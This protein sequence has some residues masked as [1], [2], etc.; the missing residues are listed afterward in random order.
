MFDKRLQMKDGAQGNSGEA[1]GSLFSKRKF[2]GFLTG[3]NGG[4][5]GRPKGNK[6]NQR[7]IEKKQ[8]N[9]TPEGGDGG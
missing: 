4:L 6:K 9:A 5:E 1:R 8:K 2:Y 3:G 7:R